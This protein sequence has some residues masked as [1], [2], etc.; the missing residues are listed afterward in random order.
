MSALSALRF[1]R[2]SFHGV[3][4]GVVYMT[5]F[6]A[7]N[8]DGNFCPTVG[9]CLALALF[10]ICGLIWTWKI[11]CKITHRRSPFFQKRKSRA[12]LVVK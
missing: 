7:N 11:D 12:A 9:K 10:S 2:P 3:K 5:A 8:G 1:G 4:V 6:I